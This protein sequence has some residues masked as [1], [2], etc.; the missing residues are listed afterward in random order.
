VRKSGGTG[1]TAINAMLQNA[2]TLD[3]RTGSIVLNNNVSDSGGNYIGGG[4][5]VISNGTFTASGTLT[6]SNLVLAGGTLMGNGTIKGLITW[7]GGRFGSGNNALTLAA[8]ATLVLAG[9]N[10]TD[11]SMAQIVTNA[12]I[13]RIVSG[14]LDIQYCGG[15]N[16][17]QLINL[18]GGL[19]DMQADVSI[20]GDSCSPGLS[21]AGTVRKSGGTGVTAINAMLQNTGTLDIRV[22]TVN[23]AAGS[24]LAAG[25]LSFALNGLTD[26]GKLTLASSAALGGPLTVKVSGNFAP[27][28]GNQFQVVTAF[29]LSGTFSS[30]NVPAGIS[31][32][33]SN[34]GVY[35]VVVGAVPVQI[36]SPQLAGTNFV[37]Q[38]ATASGQSYTIQRNDDLTT[39][40]WVY[41]TNLVGSG[42]V[43]QFQT[44]VTATPSKRFFR[45]REP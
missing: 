34:N 23:L 37:F 20:S 30:M 44:P 16:Y 29:G 4:T 9:V 41:Y 13:I 43:V 35:L 31:V 10:G 32:N 17:G 7:T 18:P 27:A 33:Y 26:F 42:S 5:V 22:G 21:N 38:F 1:V 15:G 11:Y 6:S 19:V 8:N 28:I 14:N 36:L 12:G 24:A 45:V 39:T 2:G 40:N 3:V 25:T